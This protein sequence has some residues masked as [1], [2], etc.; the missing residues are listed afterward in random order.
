MGLNS[1]I[2][3]LL[4]LVGF[5]LL[6]FFIVKGFSNV[7]PLHSTLLILLFLSSVTFFVL[8]GLVQ[9]I[10]VAQIQRLDRVKTQ[11]T[12]LKLQVRTIRYGEMTAP[13][14][15]RTNLMPLLAEL[16]RLSLERG[17]VWREVPW[18]S[19]ANGELSI[20]VA[21]SAAGVPPNAP[22]AAGIPTPPGTAGGESL[23]P[24]M[25]VYI[26]GEGPDID[27]RLSPV[28]YLGEFFIT[29]SGADSSKLNPTINL[30]P[31]QLAA[32]TSGQ[33]RTLSIYELM[34]VDSH[35][36][37]AEPDSKRTAD[38]IFGR[39]SPEIISKLLGI[40]LELREKSPSAMTPEEARK[41]TTLNSY[42]LDGQTAPQ[43]TQPEEIWQQIKFLKEYSLDVDSLE[44][45]PAL[46]GGYFD[47]AG[48]TV[49]SRL[50]NA[51]DKGTVNFKV[52]EEVVFANE[53]AEAL[54]KS[55]T[56]QRIKYVYVRPLTDYAASFK[57]I[58]LRDNKAQQDL[59]TAQREADR[60]KTTEGVGQQQMVFKQTERKLLSDDL[61]QMQKEVEVARKESE[62]LNTELADLRTEMSRLFK[63]SQEIYKR[64][65]EQQ[66]TIASGAAAN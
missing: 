13:T 10:R 33:F 37:F 24:Q 49:D 59:E 19:F 18:Q 26:F 52:D 43:G 22:A 63:S 23:A 45:R 9:S 2:L 57:D 51:A 4:L 6:I 21:R 17:R 34:P 41:A 28:F 31:A 1:I 25:I 32:L 40:P 35:Y 11:N 3:L 60:A 8:T 12:D 65:V 42:L 20:G 30:N 38:D 55:G 54:V 27:G 29:A 62:R 14:T 53:P 66:Q 47:V 48:R 44:N 64:V 7:G 15:E 5:I 56:A 36:A 46:E 16:G 50:K 61:T 39:M 58:Q